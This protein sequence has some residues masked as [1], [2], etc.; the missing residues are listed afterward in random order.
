MKATFT[1]GAIALAALVAAISVN[2]SS[3]QA[4]GYKV[5]SPSG[6]HLRSGPSKKHASRGVLPKGTVVCY[7]GKKGKWRKVAV[8]SYNTGWMYR[9]WLSFNRKLCK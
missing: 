1:T 3:A 5:T 9:K 8:P 2:T 7:M 4:G 6:L